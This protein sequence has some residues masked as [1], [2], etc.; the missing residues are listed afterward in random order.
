MERTIPEVSPPAITSVAFSDLRFICRTVEVEAEALLLQDH[1][2][3]F[4]KVEERRGF[5]KSV[6]RI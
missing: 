5:R 4:Q 3:S 6:R 1:S 2:L